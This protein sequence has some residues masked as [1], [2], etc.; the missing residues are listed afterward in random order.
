[1]FEEVSD[2]VWMVVTVIF[3]PWQSVRSGSMI[4]GSRK[5][6]TRPDTRR[7]WVELPSRTLKACCVVGFFLQTDIQL[8]EHVHNQSHFLGSCPMAN[9]DALTAPPSGAKSYVK[10]ILILLVVATGGVLF[11]QYGD[12]LSIENL[13]KQEAELRAFQSEHPYLVYGI[14]FGVY[15]AVTGLS[16]PG[17]AALTLVY[18]WYFGFL[19][20]VILVSF[21]STM[22]ATLAFLMSRYLLRGSVQAKFGD[23]LKS[24]NEQLDRDGAFY[25]F[26]LRLIP[27][28][29]FF[30]INLV[31]G[32]TPVKARTFWW[33]SQ[34]GML[35]GTLVFVYAG[36]RV[37][38]LTILAEEGAAAV[39]SASQ[40]VQITIAFA[41]LGTFPLLVRLI[42]NRFSSRPTAKA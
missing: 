39:F 27:A 30:V 26:T 21:A 12:L 3:P 10:P 8:C 29:P 42:L 34:L 38:N 14:A 28:V 11:F 33:V 13:A 24:F 17:A 1:M 2:A 40:L 23:R 20:T 4:G 31:M 18:G 37:P 22:G 41:L 6:G 32:L 19:R 16:L 5:S 35:P 9:D 7:W 25:L 36:S 15:V